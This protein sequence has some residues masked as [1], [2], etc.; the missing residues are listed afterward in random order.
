MRLNQNRG[1]RSAVRLTLSVFAVGMMLV[2]TGYTGAAPPRPA[3]SPFDSLGHAA[4]GWT[5]PNADTSNTRHVRG[6]ISSRNVDSLEVA[7]KVPVRVPAP[8]E[9]WP[10]V[11]ATTPVVINGIVY[12]QDLDSNVY[13]I[14][15]R[16]GRVLWTRMYD[17]PINGP[18]GVNVVDGRVHGATTSNAFALDARTGRE[19]W[20]RKLIRNDNEGINMS[21]GVNRGTVYVST[22]PGNADAFFGGGG[23]GVLWALD[24]RTGRT[25]WTFNS[26]P[27]DLWGHPELNS[28]GGVWFPP[29][30]DARGNLYFSVG[31][32]APFLGT[33]E[34][35]W[36][37]SRPGPNLYTNSVVKLDHR[38]GKVIWYNQVLPHDIYD[39]DLQ[40]SPVLTHA[41]G[42]PVVV[43]A[44]KAGFVYQ[45]DPE[46][47]RMLWKTSVGKH[48][49]HDEDNLHAMNEE[50]D[51]LPALP[52]EVYP[53]VLGGV[54]SPIAVDRTTVYASVNNYSATWVGQ[55]SPPQLSSFSEGT[56]ELVAL[57]LVTGR[58][59]WSH[60][61]PASPYGAASVVNDLVF[62]TTFDGTLHA[63]NTR[64]GKLAWQSKLPAHSNSAVAINGEYVITGAGWPQA[65]G[66]KAEIVAYRLDR[67]DGSR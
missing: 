42:R 1:G 15:L 56:G 59:K 38:T 23:A 63:V 55:D 37:S 6:P 31:N 60:P 54:I 16:T 58:I 25:K 50:Y 52:V 46:T 36:A 53:G 19:I 17:S 28:G 20:S 62:T 43:A 8:P 34:F 22:G 57:D 32:P 47:G 21:P 41:G 26:V 51:K 3:T 67:K 33:K 44:G 40:N 12:T 7:W 29:S 49:G 4:T 9:R 45:F 35:P 30:F 5:A 65:P 2:L 27:L 66:E 13:A 14:D 10:G 64:T 39:W 48:N 11:Y 18:N 61:L 24:A